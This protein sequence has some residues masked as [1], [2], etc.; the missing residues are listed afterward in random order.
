[1]SADWEIGDKAVCISGGAPRYS[2]PHTV[3]P[4][5]EGAIYEVTGVWA[6]PL[7]TSA[8]LLVNGESPHF[9]VGNDMP[10]GWDSERFSKIKPDA[11]ED[12]E[13]EFV[14][15]LQRIKSPAKQGADS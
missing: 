3:E 1:V 7:Q 11:H 10:S 8:H 14:T 4:L 12:C 15:L 9:H 6:Y 5:I 13:P 2:C